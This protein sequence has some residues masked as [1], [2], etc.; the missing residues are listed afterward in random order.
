MIDKCHFDSEKHKCLA[1]QLLFTSPSPGPGPG[2]SVFIIPCPRP[3][4]CPNTI[5]KKTLKI[6]L[7]VPYSHQ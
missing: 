5:N 3:S 4:P 2:P 6:I 1:L 7:F